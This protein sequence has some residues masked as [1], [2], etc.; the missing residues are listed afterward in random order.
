MKRIAI[1]LAL[2]AFA[3]AASAQ[4][5][6]PT[7]EMQTVAPSEG[8]TRF[9]APV[10]D[11][12]LVRT[13]REMKVAATAAAGQVIM[14]MSVRHG[15]TMVLD[16]ETQLRSGA[17]GLGARPPALPAGL[18]FYKLPDLRSAIQF[19]GMR[20]DAWCTLQW[21]ASDGVRREPFCLLYR[22]GG[23]SSQDVQMVRP[24]FTNPLL[25]QGAN[26]ANGNWGP[27]PPIHEAD[28][29]FPG[30]MTAQ[31]TFV[32]AQG[33]NLSIRMLVTAHL[34]GYPDVSTVATTEAP[35]VNGVAYFGMGRSTLMVRPMP[36]STSY[37]LQFDGAFG[38]WI[39]Q[40]KA[41]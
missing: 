15:R 5:P 34:D 33:N 21:T 27:R 13:D 23:T 26:I 20:F 38:D 9:V 30:E 25:M 14:T 24:V 7:A 17:W 32:G 6:A 4:A 29:Q 8:Q 12:L 1:V 31:V 10:M 37:A 18:G 39:S 3:G 2:L 28:V 36:D 19:A 22:E 40:H 11:W 35:M 16:T 41:P